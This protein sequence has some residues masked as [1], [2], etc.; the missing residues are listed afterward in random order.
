MTMNCTHDHNELILFHAGELPQAEVG[1]I[2]DQISTCLSCQEEVSSLEQVAVMPE[3]PALDPE[4]LAA[5]RTGAYARIG[6]SWQAR[7]GRLLTR[8]RGVSL[9]LRPLPE[10]ALASLLLFVGY[11][12]GR[13]QGHVALAPVAAEADFAPSRGSVFDVREIRIDESTGLAVLTLGTVREADVTGGLGD[14][15]VAD[16]LETALVSGADDGIRLR[17]LKTVNALARG[18]TPDEALA[19]AVIDMIGM[20]GH[21]ALRFRAIGALAALYSDSDIPQ[22]GRVALLNALVSDAGDG[23]RIAALDVLM[24]HETSPSD[25]GILRQALTHDSN[26]YVRLSVARALEKLGVDGSAGQRPEGA[27]SRPLERLN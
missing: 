4:A 5:A 23:V 27:E 1:R 22:V 16:A 18:D 6:S 7:R 3:R 13:G 20:E 25:V 24:A 9:G 14:A 21:D 10:L 19:Q 2:R 26:S 11:N 8:L 15:F 12:F 17:A